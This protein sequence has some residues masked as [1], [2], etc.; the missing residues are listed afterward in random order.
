MTIKIAKKIVKY[1]VEKPQDKAEKEAAEKASAQNQ[2][3]SR[4]ARGAWPRSS[5]CTKVWSG[6][7]C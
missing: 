3:C 5:A 2:R 4:T 7:R 1:S 6:L